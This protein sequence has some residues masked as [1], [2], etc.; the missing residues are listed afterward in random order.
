MAQQQ[1]QHPIFGDIRSGKLEE[2]Q[3]RVRADAAVLEER[4]GWGG[5]TSLIYAVCEGKPAIAL[6]LIEHRG[7]HDLDSTDTY[8]QTALH[9]TCWQDSLSVVKALVGA[10]ANLAALNQY[11]STPLSRAAANN[12]ANIVAFLLQQP[13]VKTTIDI[14]SH[15]PKTALSL[16][17]HYGHR[18]IVQLL[19]DAGADPTIPAGPH[20]PINRA[21]SKGHHAIASL[22]RTAIA[23]PQRPRALLKAR[24]LLDAALA[25]P[26]ARNDS[27]DK[28]EP[29]AVQQQQQEAA[30]A[31]APAY[32]K[33]RVA[34]GRE[35]PAIVVVVKDDSSNEEEEELVACVK[36]AL[37]LDGGGAVHEEGQGPPPQGMVHDVFIELCELLV[38]A[39]DRANV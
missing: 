19:L 17:S 21:I 30:I 39:W 8:G 26:Q 34:E 23:E 28:G 31:A 4:G 15:F 38:P 2:V 13:A 29:Q 7:Q 6:W 37:E 1:Q 16:A 20:S 24:A 14:I 27:A 10:G 5:R 3:R 33:G 36:Y 11:K 32:L 12:H 9:Y 35:L 22:L 18:S 25:T